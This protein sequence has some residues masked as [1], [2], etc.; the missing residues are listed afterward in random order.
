VIDTPGYADFVSDVAAALRAADLAVFVVSAVE[1][2]EVQTE[3]AW[4]LA[5]DLSTRRRVYG[6]TPPAVPGPAA[7]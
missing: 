6:R 4:K 5:E 1:G 7:P 2:V 3:V